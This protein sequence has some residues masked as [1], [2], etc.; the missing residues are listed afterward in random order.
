[1]GS[2]SATG[3][4]TN[5]PVV[6]LPLYIY[7]L[8]KAWE[9]LFDL[10]LALPSVLFVTVVNPCNG[11]GDDA[12]PDDSYRDV[13]QR[14]SSVPNIRILGYVH[15]TYGSRPLDAIRTDIDVYRAWNSSFRVDGIFFDETPSDPST[16]EFMTTASDHTRST[17]RKSLS[18]PGLVAFN[19]GVVVQR[20]FFDAADWI[21]VFEQSQTHWNTPDIQ[22]AL[23]QMPADVQHKAVAIVHSLT[24]DLGE[25]SQLTADIRL[26][27]FGGLHLT[28]QVGGGYTAWPVMWA[29]VAHALAGDPG[30]E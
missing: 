4:A 16:L 13:L 1:M 25:A 8:E 19:P 30:S 18:R 12:L 11:P 2:I 15:C 7:P 3:L 17:W 10:A 23:Q 29:S 5:Q 28:E 14:L 27:G 6:L 9:P 22:D 24:G 21:V 26:R 20:A